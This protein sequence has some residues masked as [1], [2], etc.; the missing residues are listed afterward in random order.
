MMVTVLFFLKLNIKDEIKAA[1]FLDIE[2][3]KKKKK[4]KKKNRTLYYCHKF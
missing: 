2:K 1:R 4:K 3:K